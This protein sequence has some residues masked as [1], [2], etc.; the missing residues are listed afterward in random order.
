[1]GQKQRVFQHNGSLPTFAAL[2]NEI[3]ANTAR[4]VSSLSPLQ[5]ALTAATNL[6]QNRPS[7]VFQQ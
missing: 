5:L 2:A 1:M 7:Q 3:S 4:A 6:R